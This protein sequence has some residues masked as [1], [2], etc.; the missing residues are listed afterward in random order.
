LAPLHR[1][2]NMLLMLWYSGI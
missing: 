2:E 1:T